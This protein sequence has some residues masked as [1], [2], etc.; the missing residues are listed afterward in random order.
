ME[1]AE[2]IG[3]VTARLTRR[4]PWRVGVGRP[5]AG[6]RGI[7]RSYREALDALDLAGR[8]DLPQPVVHARDLLVYRVLLR[9]ETAMADLVQTVLGPLITAR[10]GADPLLG[11]LE[12]YFR[13]GCNAAETARRMHLRVRAVTYRLERVHALTGRSAVEPADHLTLLVA[14]TGARMLDWPA[15]RLLTD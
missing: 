4:P 15:R 2:P 7:L 6:P 5:H 11:T 12:S 13:T 3:R 14:V 9:D 1:L 10:G 8:L